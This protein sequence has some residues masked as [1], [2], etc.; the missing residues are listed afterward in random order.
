MPAQLSLSLPY[1][2]DTDFTQLRE[3]DKLDQLFLYPSNGWFRSRGETVPDLTPL[4]SL[5]RISL[6]FPTDTSELPPLNELESLIQLNLNLGASQ[7]TN[8]EGLEKLNR[9]RML[10]INGYLNLQ[11]STLYKIPSSVEILRF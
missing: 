5:N 3:I 4:N 11:R 1:T 2:K 6:E 9:L 8:L 10:S 7:I